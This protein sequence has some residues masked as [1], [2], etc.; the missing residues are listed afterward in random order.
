MALFIN[1]H[2]STIYCEVKRNGRSKS[3][4][5]ET[6]KRQVYLRGQRLVQPRTFTPQIKLKVE[7]LIRKKQWSP[8]QIIGYMKKHR[9][10]IVSHETI[11]TFIRQDRAC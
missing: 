2:I 10:P 8:K 3:Y 4:D 5:Y 1:V 6:A 11:Y 7:Q 9:E